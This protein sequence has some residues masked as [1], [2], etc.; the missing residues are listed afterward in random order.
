MP[1]NTIGK[2]WEWVKDHTTRP[3]AR[4]LDPMRGFEVPDLQPIAPIEET[5]PEVEPEL[6]PYIVQAPER[7]TD[8]LMSAGVDPA[9]R[10]MGRRAQ[11]LSPSLQELLGIQVPTIRGSTYRQITAEEDQR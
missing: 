7:A 8:P 3:L 5:E 1:F 4:A 10:F 9:T 11:R 6:N 2:A